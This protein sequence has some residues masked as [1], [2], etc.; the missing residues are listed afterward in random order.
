MTKVY[1]YSLLDFCITSV[2]PFKWFIGGQFIVSIIWAVDLS[3]RPYLIKIIL[4]AISTISS[5]ESFENLLEA[6]ILYVIVTAIYMV[7]FRFYDWILL[8]LNPELKKHIVIMLMSRLMNHS[9]SFYQDQFSGSIANKVNDISRGIPNILSLL[10]DRFFSHSLAL[11]IAI[12]TVWTVDL[13]FAIALMFWVIIFLIFSLK[14]SSKAK[15]LSHKAAEINSLVVGYIVDILANI[16]SIRLFES[17]IYETNYLNES[18]KLT[19]DAEQKRDWC[20]I[21]IHTFQQG[22][23]VIFQAICIYWLIIGVKNNNTTP[24]DFALIM[25]LNISIIS[26]LYALS[27]DIREFTQSLGTITQGF[28]VINSSI[29]VQD[30]VGAQD[31]VISRGEITFERV[32]FNYIDSCPLFKNISIRIEAGQKIGLVG[33]SGSGK[34]TFVNLILRLFDVKKGHILIDGQDIKSVSQKSLRNS[35]GIIPQDIS[36]FNRTLMNNIRYGRLNASDSE[37]VEAAKCAYAHEF[38]SKL[39][40]GYNTLVGEKGVKLSG[41]ERQRIAIARAILKNAPILILDEATNQ[42]DSLTEKQIQESLD[43]V[44]QDKTV[45]VI[46]HR[47]STL[48]KMDRIIV[49]Y[50]GKIVQDGEHADLIIQNGL[51]K[52]LWES[53]IGEFLPQK[54]D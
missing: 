1:N 14:L 19:I 3:L 37:V 47:L 28:R 12:Y 6:S 15:L 21:K 18:Y 41:G 31:I 46:A 11:L 44:M 13:K 51:Y 9:Q 43:Q 54:P 26:C 38:I 50:E 52:K 30:K 8:W 45:L 23:F 48:L 53:H 16:V 17:K 24:G 40:K 20:F 42:L 36:L 22:S 25:I 27:R 7:I 33:F 4:N 35:I 49:F 34:S 10:I 29:D 2:K 32:Y 5:S 39:S